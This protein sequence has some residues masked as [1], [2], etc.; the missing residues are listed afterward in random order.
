LFK[1]ALSVTTDNFIINNNLAVVYKSKGYHGKALNQLALALKIK[2][3][4]YD[5][6]IN[7][8]NIDE[9]MEGVSKNLINSLYQE[10]IG[11]VIQY[12]ELSFNYALFQEKQKSYSKAVKYYKVAVRLKKGKSP[13]ALSNLGNIYRMTG[14][15]GKA[16][17]SF[18]AA[19]RFDNKFKEALFNLA[20][21]FHQQGKFTKALVTYRK[22]LAF[23]PEHLNSLA[24]GGAAAASMKNYEEAVLLY[25]RALKIDPLN[26]IVR[27]NLTSALSR[28][29]TIEG[30]DARSDPAPD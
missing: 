24:N 1:Q 18:Q 26:K 3:D 5:A 21:L 16:E 13:E 25:K 19:L 12:P 28:K 7:L 4:Y 27:E 30:A 14:K 10:S 9:S 29:S 20:L 17:K 22:I 8:G 11:T 23:D 15:F 6:L 2:P